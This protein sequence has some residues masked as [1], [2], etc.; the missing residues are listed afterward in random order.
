MFR[1]TYLCNSSHFP[2]VDVSTTTVDLIKDIL[3]EFWIQEI[4]WLRYPS[5]NSEGERDWLNVILGHKPGQLVVLLYRYTVFVPFDCSLSFLIPD[6]PFFQDH[7]HDPINVQIR[8]SVCLK[9]RSDYTQFDL[10]I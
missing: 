7:L 1:P 10:E 2:D 5:D 8:E 9:L 6:S 4:F 3:T